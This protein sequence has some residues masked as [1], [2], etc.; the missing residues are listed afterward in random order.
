MQRWVSIPEF[1]NAIRASFVQVL[2]VTTARDACITGDLPTAE[3]LLTQN[4]HT[5]ANDYTSHA[6][7]SFVMARQRNWDHALQDAIKVS[8]IDSA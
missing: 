2:A 4:I 7:R 1:H 3:E 5:D 6:Y 8:N